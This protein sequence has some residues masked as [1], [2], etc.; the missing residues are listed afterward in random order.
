M[1]FK[2]LIDKTYEHHGKKKKRVMASPVGGTPLAHKKRKQLKKNLKKD[3]GLLKSYGT[4]AMRAKTFLSDSSKPRKKKYGIM[5]NIKK[6]F[7]KT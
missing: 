1:K 6:V 3:E 5:D 4:D 2:T 7:T